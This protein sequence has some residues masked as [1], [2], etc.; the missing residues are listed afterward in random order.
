VKNKIDSQMAEKDI[1][2]LLK[3]KLPNSDDG[4][5]ERYNEFKNKQ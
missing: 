1:L 4:L 5:L 2:T 3:D